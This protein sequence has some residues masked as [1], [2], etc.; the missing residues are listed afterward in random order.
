MPT[1]DVSYKDI[2]NLIG[3]RID[4]GKLKTKAIMFA[5]GEIEEFEDD[6]IK[7]DEKD[8]NRPDLWSTEGLAREIAGRYGKEGLP[9][10][11]TEPSGL[12]VKVHESVKNVRPFTVCA[13]MR[14][15][16]IT[17]DLL[18]Q[19]IQLQEK[20]AGT[21]GK[22]RRDVAIGI[23][24]Y[25]KIK[26]NI[27]YR[28]YK[29]DE[30]SFTPL[31]FGKELK[32]SEILKEHPKGREFGH[33]LEGRDRYPIFIDDGGNVLSMPPVINSN[34][35]G[36]V[37]ENTTDVFIECSGFDINV[38]MPALNVIVCALADRGGKVQ[39]VHVEYAD[40]DVTTPD[41]TPKI[42]TVRKGYVKEIMGMDM[43]DKTMKK[44]LLQAR[45]DVEKITSRVIKV[46][47]PAY[48]QDIMHERDVIEDML[49]S[50]GYNEI[51]P[52]PV[53]I[54][55]KGMLQPMHIFSNNVAE[56]MIGLG[57]QEILSYTLTNKDN[58]F[59]KMSMPET[60]V[61]ELENPVSA[62][63]SVFRN[64]L[65]PGIMEF[66]SKNKHHELPQKVFEI[67]A[68]IIPDSKSETMYRDNQKLACGIIASKV[69][70]DEISSMIDAFLRAV[71]ISYELK[72]GKH[73]SF[74]D[75]RCAKVVA[76]GK[77]IGI[78]GEIHPHALNNWGI[79]NPVIAF[80]L[81]LDLVYNLEANQK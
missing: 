18:I 35:T 61:C 29:P 40:K 65:L 39:T 57:M 36:K 58:L 14:N 5:K 45:Y 41:L 56:V 15:L 66:F 62:N 67:G 22:N 69:T 32:L 60:A 76:G 8:T 80:E 73:P 64:A 70:Y 33:L 10:Y 52:E 24:D 25:N 68:C 77:C 23:Y 19:M 37:T 54:I 48:R 13:V 20:I 3:K 34:Y 11:E 51:E 46:L 42:A 27:H 1:I 78:V 59:R 47:Y 16:N 72:A 6:E 43:D 7:V 26:G 9:E 50:L 4:K 49:I 12:V 63:W 17:E 21:Y 74:I 53:K 55:T 75:G 81:D 79:E 44:L 38:L 2:C 31:E 71:G 30:L 28:G